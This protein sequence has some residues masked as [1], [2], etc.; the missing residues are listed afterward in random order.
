MLTL[1]QAGRYLLIVR[2]ADD[3]TGAYRIKI[4]SG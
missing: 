1:P 2:G 3:A 4:Q